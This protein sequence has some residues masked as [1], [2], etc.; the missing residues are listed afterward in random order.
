MIVVKPLDL[1]TLG[2]N[3]LLHREW[4]AA[5][6]NGAFASSTLCGLNTRKYHGLLV[7][8]MAPPVRRMVL[9]SRVEETVHGE[10]HSFDLACNEYPGVIHPQGYR[11]LCAFHHEPF[12]RWAYQGK[13]W[14]IEKQLRPIRG[15]NLVVLSYS[16]LGAD[17]PI[18]LELRPLFA[19]RGIHELTYQCNGKLDPRDLSNTHH[20]IPATSRSPE[21]FFAHDGAFT[22]QACWYL[23][24]IYRREQERGYGGLEDLWMPGA[25]KWTVRP[26]QTV[27]FVCSTE[28]IDFPQA[29]AEA[30]REY[31]STAAP[32]RVGE[33]DPA[34]DMLARA[35]TQ[36]V[37]RGG[38]D[39]PAVMTAYPWSA[40]SGRDAMI[41]LP[42]LFLVTGRLDEARTL[43]QDFAGLIHEGLMP[44]ELAED[45]S[46]YRYNAADTSLWFVHAAGQYV[47]YGG[48]PTFA[49]RQL[50]PAMNRIIDAY[51][52]GTALGIEVD[53]DGLLQTSGSGIPT[54]WMDARVGQWAV[55]PRHGRPVSLVALWY[56]ALRTTADL[57]RRFGQINRAEDLESL[58]GLAKEGFHRRF[59][60]APAQCCYDVVGDD[61]V[62]ASIR[63]NQIFAV[64]LPHA[65]LDMARHAAVVEKVR[66]L[67]LTP[68]GVRT[69]APSD[70]NYHGTY[71]G[72]P[73]ARDRAYHQ[74]CAFP[75]LL[76]P[77]VSAYIRLNGR[78]E[79]ARHEARRMLEGCLQYMRNWGMGQLCEL[80]DG[81]TPHHPDGA[82]A[83]ARSVAEILRCYVEDVRDA[84]PAAPPPMRA[85]DTQR[86][87]GEEAVRV[88]HTHP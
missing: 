69:L 72:P 22:P 78:G 57:C 71:A 37:V 51:R 15:R 56:N 19:L 34:V 55:T 1:S 59:W 40:P 20:R 12:P 75:W 61:R 38:G 76:G 31:E 74:G 17:K 85:E 80:F 86:A 11:L 47:R 46:G 53:G 44:S 5:L 87:N 24:T 10:G 14:T 7:A 35:A 21:V 88:N 48:D 52:A 2:F 9:L 3:D 67:L 23:N 30:D 43:L 54:T 73:A 66:S 65:I 45:G 50:L 81:E 60:N 39:V 36:F 25:V 63:P 6:G 83:S 28:P 41:C 79:P 82:V 58:A 26:G 32:V 8:A 27:N 70:D 16:L 13:G 84:V 42:G 18:D 77:L 29:V 49:Q 62:D 4:L 64:S 68:Y 33:A